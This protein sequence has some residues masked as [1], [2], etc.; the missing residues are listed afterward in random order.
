MPQNTFNSEEI[1]EEFTSIA[2]AARQDRGLFY[3]V[4]RCMPMPY[5]LVDESERVLQT[6]E[7]LLQMLQIEGSVNDC[8]GKKLA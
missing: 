3:A 2:Q 5:L 6:N 1:P 7:A 4:L 8:V